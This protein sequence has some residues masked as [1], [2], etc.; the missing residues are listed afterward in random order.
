MNILDDLEKIKRLDKSS[1]L[2]S[3][4]Q[5]W[6]Q[7]KQTQEELKD[8]KIPKTYRN[9]NRIVINGMGGSRLG[10]RVAAKLFEDSL[11]IPIIPIGSYTLPAFVDDK[12]LLILSS[13][14]G[15]TEEILTSAK[16]AFKRRAKILVFAQNGKLTEIAQEE[17]LPGYYGFIHKYNPCN[18][19]RMSLGYQVLGIILLL[20]KCGLLNI[21]SNEIIDLLNFVKRVKSRC[22][23]NVPQKDNLAK[24]VAKKIRE[25]IPVL[26]AAEFLMGAVHVWRNQI[27]E[28]AKQL[29]VYFEIPELNH[30]L[31]EGMKFP[32]NNPRN[33]FFVFIKSDLYHPINQK[34][35]EITKQ[36]L[37]GYKIKY[38]DVRLS[39]KTKLK[40]VFE[41]IQFGS[42]VSFYLSILN[43]LDPTPVPWVDFFKEKLKKAIHE[44]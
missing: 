17:N 9:I 4:Q 38:R 19:P 22:D 40:Q 23:I 36:V 30:H 44:R 20:S 18:Q 24:K 5:L 3:V 31:L 11:E 10:G 39:G 12:T 1:L 2:G 16:E 28:S 29:A 21:S 7:L 32:K 8:L 34:R 13:Y 14:S 43:Y 42:Y 37:N 25:K 27:N 15:N 35:I 26:V 6:L 41:L 33:L